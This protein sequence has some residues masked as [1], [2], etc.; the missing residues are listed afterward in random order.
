MKIGVVVFVLLAA[1]T[2]IAGC[3]LS[4]SPPPKSASG[5][6]ALPADTVRDV[7]RSFVGPFEFETVLPVDLKFQVVVYDGSGAARQ[8]GDGSALIAELRDSSGRV[9]YAGRVLPDGTLDAALKL[10]AAPEDMTLTLEGAGFEARR[11]VIP[12]MV[13]YSEINR[14][15]GMLI[16]TDA[17]RAAEDPLADSD[18]DLIPD[19]YDAFPKDPNAAF[20]Y[21]TPANGKLTVAFEDLFGLARAGDADYNDFIA[22]YTVQEIANGANAITKI[23]VDAAADTK[24]A[25]YHHK[26]G[27]RIDAF[28]GSATL[29]GTYIDGM[30]TGR[31]FGPCEKTAPLNVVLFHDS[32]NAVG[33]TASFTLEFATPQVIEAGSAKVDRP[34]YNPYLYVHNTGTE[35]HLMGEQDTSGSTSESFQD[36]EGFPWAL[37]VPSDWVHPDEGQRIEIPYPRFTSWRESF[38]QKD[39][40]WYLPVSAVNSP[41]Y[42]V[43]AGWKATGP[44]ST[45]GA[46]TQTPLYVVGNSTTYYQLQIQEVNGLMDPDGDQVV[47]KSDALPAYMSLDADT[48]LVTIAPNP[49]PGTAAIGFWSED[50]K[51]A[52]TSGTPYSVTFKF[53]RS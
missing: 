23:I 15:V 29:S 28:E 2:L 9:A 44:G 20:A 31:A 48:G 52:S 42:P 45:G 30:G 14:T 3:S 10:A 46:V 6:T 41:P 25:G 24:L 47:F 13:Q 5:G 38:G 12:R 40:D 35:I 17:V 49:T 4:V 11:I 50:A 53:V 27:I 7:S 26:F 32:R 22:K 33:R 21:Q 36:A 51:G 1:L 39:S 8:P 34:P 19:V 16:D 37:L 43:I 18:G